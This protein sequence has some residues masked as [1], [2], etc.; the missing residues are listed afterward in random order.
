MDLEKIKHELEELIQDYSS[1]TLAN[2]EYEAG[3]VRG[4]QL[5]LQIVEM[6]C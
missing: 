5:A 6:D 2:I 3:I 1:M 4:L